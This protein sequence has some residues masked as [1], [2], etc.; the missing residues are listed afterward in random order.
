MKK[1]FSFVAIMTFFACVI[2][3]YN[4]TN[5]AES[6][7]ELSNP[8][9]LSGRKSV[10]GGALFSSG[11]DSLVNNP[12]LTAK[13]Q[14]VNLGVGYS[15]LHSSNEI[16]DSKIGSAFQT[17][18]L[19]PSKLY[20]FS[21]YV[22]GTFIPF[23]EMNLGNSINVKA[24]L[25][26][27]ITE[28]LDV[29]LSLNGGFGWGNKN[30]WSLSGNLGFL[31]KIGEIG[32]LK[33][34]RYGVSVVNLGKNYDFFDNFVTLKV[35]VASSLLKS[36]FV[37]LGLSFDFTTPMFQNLLI[38]V[39]LQC[40]IK[41]MIVVSVLEKININEISNGYKNFIPSVSLSFKFPLTIKNNEYLEKNDWSQSEMTVNAGWKNVY[42]NVNVIS[43]SADVDLGMVDTSAPVITIKEQM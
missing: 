24:G 23:T 25:S 2:F 22:N 34:F 43:V 28:K 20:I 29:G 26:K 10:V 16:N 3:A 41:K 17:A 12:A 35:G 30:D 36:E 5:G 4:P 14:R 37:N 13:E 9:S 40:E 11:A 19:I 8:N 39:N 15:F 42:E 1:I 18:I 7:F 32:F 31:Y 21:G 38:D 33:D 6:M 27:E